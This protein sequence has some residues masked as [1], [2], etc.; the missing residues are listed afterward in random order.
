MPPVAAA[1][2]EWFG[3]RGAYAALAALAL[4]LGGVAALFVDSSPE[5][6]GLAPDGEAPRD[7][8]PAA[9]S[10][11]GGVALAE[12]ARTRPFW[13]L[14]TASTLGGIGVFIPF[15]HLVPYAQ[16]VGVART[17]AVLLLGLIGIG[18]TVGRFLLGGIADRVGRRRSVAAMWFGM[19]AM[20]LFWLAARDA[21]TLG[22]FALVFGLFYGGFVA[23]IP[24]L[25]ADYFGT[26]HLSGII[27]VQYTGVGFGTLIGPTVAG[28]AYDVAQSYALPILGVAAAAAAA[29]L[30]IL[31]TAEPRHAGGG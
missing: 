20:L 31:A 13:L 3:W 4:G 9:A 12:A 27:G 18:S 23:L 21:W 29:G 17:T 7:G 1:F 2:I 8:L 26:R 22:L 15:V 19:A 6:R 25:I 16:G 14:F 28:Y 24:A 11:G 10:D 5:R 30:L